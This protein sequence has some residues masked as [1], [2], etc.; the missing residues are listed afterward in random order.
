MEALVERTDASIAGRSET[1]VWAA[2]VKGAPHAEPRGAGA[3]AA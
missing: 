1:S 3:G 2:E